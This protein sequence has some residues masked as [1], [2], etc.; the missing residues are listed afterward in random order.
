MIIEEYYALKCVVDIN[1]KYNIHISITN[2]V[3]N[4]IDNHH[5]EKHQMELLADQLS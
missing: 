4:I 3:N 2:A 5:D 1:K